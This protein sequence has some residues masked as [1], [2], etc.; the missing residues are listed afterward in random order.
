MRVKAV[1]PLECPSSTSEEYC[2]EVSILF[3]LMKSLHTIAR[4]GII[5]LRSLF[6]LIFLKILQII[7]GPV[8][9]LGSAHVSIFW[10]LR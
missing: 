1:L 6:F 3:L 2:P 4:P 10:A 8:A 7:R 5:V 9:A